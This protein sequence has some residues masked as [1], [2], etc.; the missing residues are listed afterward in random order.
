MVYNFVVNF[1]FDCNDN[2]TFSRSA[3]KKLNNATTT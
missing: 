1:I 3:F 2:T